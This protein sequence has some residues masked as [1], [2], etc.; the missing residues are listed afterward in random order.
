MS[1]TPITSTATTPQI[2]ENFL[3]AMFALTGV[4]TDATQGSIVRTYGE[5]VGAITELASATATASTFQGGVYG[6]YSAFGITPIAATSATTTVTFSSTTPVT[7][8]VYIPAGTI[9][10][11]VS[12]IQ[13]YTNAAVTIAANTT[14]ASV[15]ATAQNPGT[16]GNVQANTITQ[17]LSGVT[18]PI[19]VTNPTAATG[20]T[21]QETPQQTAARF[22]A[23]INSLGTTSPIAVAN[24]VIGVNYQGEYVVQS[25]VYE[26]WITNPSA[27]AG[28]TIYIDNGYG[29]ASSNLVQAVTNFVNTTPGYRPAGV[30]YSIDP[31]TAIDITITVTGV[32]FSQYA[33]ELS[34]LESAIQTSVESY[35]TSV[36]IG[37][38]ITLGSISAAAANGAPSALS[39]LNVSFSAGGDTITAAYN[40]RIIATSITVD[41]SS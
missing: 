32:V 38:S 16:A 14:S 31:V 1:G 9:V 29:T 19:S 26:P 36:Q 30:P 25:S 13:F 2:A 28:F 40:Q 24:A 15:G 27:G 34:T 7:S 11:T 41:L 22:S 6:A 20:G 5:A 17:I 35:M 21:N 3:G 23:K 8:A 39:S 18:Y 33:N 10:A 37:Q 4:L 12:G